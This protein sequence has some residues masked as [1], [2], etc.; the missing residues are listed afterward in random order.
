MLRGVQPGGVGDAGKHY[1]EEDS[2][3]WIVA[4]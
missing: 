4:S 1:P 2:G 3:F